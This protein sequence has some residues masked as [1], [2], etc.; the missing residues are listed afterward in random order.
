MTS[1]EGGQ[2]PDE[3]PGEPQD[4]GNQPGEEKG[5]VGGR[6]V[7]GA[8]K[9]AKRPYNLQKQREAWTDKEHQVGLSQVTWAQVTCARV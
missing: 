6:A 3:G 8:Q 9:P 7:Q 5:S 4:A 1:Q 2:R